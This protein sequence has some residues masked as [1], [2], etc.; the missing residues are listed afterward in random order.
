MVAVYE[1]RLRKIVPGAVPLITVVLITISTP[2]P[3]G[4]SPR[5]IVNSVWVIV[6]P[7]MMA[8]GPETEPLT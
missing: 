4:I 2:L 6:P 1:A 8:A 3:G 7:G 5:L